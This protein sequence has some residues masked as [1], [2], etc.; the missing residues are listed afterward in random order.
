MIQEIYWFVGI[1]IICIIFHEIGH[2]LMLVN[3]GIYPKV[4]YKNGS[5]IIGKKEQYKKLKPE[6]YRMVM[7][8]GIVSGFI[9]LVVLNRWSFLL[10][11]IY[12]LL[13]GC[14]SDIMN[15]VKSFKS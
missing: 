8:M 2:Y 5:I 11:V 7:F 3:Y 6:E 12:Y 9:P 4:R 13:W 10:G 14:R 1:I 15:I